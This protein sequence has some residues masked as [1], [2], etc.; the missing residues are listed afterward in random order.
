[1]S[2]QAHPV[3]NGFMIGILLALSGCSAASQ[4]SGITNPG[5]VS[6]SAAQPQGI[7]STQVEVE[8][9]QTPSTTAG[10]QT[11]K[12]IGKRVTF[13]RAGLTLV[14]YLYKPAGN[15][16]FPGLIWNHGSEQNPSPP[17]QEF[18]AIAQ[19]FVPAG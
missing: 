11:Q 8:A 9:S 18:P 6:T 1:M 10:S 5:P 16:P 12:I 15:G 13:Q 3:I 7:P 14:G 17:V 2:M 19:I 4:A